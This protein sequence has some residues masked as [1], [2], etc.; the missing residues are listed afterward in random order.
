MVLLSNTLSG[1]ITASVI[2]AGGRGAQIYGGG[3]IFGRS[4]SVLVSY[5][6]QSARSQRGMFIHLSIANKSGP[7]STQR[8]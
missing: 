1:G 8:I 5:P 4:G 6:S 2:K 3:V 7:K